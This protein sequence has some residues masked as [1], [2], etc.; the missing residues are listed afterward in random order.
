MLLYKNGRFYSK[1]VSFMVPNGFYFDSDPDR[2]YSDGVIAWNSSCANSYSWTI[3]QGFQS[4]KEDLEGLFLQGYRFLS[5]VMPIQMNGLM[6]HR[7]IYRK[8][9]GSGGCYEVQFDL[10]KTRKMVFL[11]DALRDKIENVVVSS[12]FRTALDGIRAE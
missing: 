7:L 10:S 6:G 11:V 12:D 8:P 2:L 5:Q 1:D 9:E 3:Q 4:S